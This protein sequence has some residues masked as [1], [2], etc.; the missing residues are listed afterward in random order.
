MSEFFNPVTG[1]KVEAENAAE[2]AEKFEN[3]EG[4]KQ[5]KATKKGKD[6]VGSRKKATVSPSETR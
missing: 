3:G 2:A 4:T 5:T 6:G 1:E